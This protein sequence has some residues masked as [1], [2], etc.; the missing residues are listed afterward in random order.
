MY[1]IVPTFVIRNFSGAKKV[2]LL[3]QSGI[4]VFYSTRILD[5]TKKIS[6]FY[7]FLVIN[8]HHMN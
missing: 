5:M 1:C 6:A 4:T 3:I 7:N 2:K 8:L